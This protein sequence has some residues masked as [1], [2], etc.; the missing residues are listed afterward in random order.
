MRK[1]A[2]ATVLTFALVGAAQLAAAEKPA[3]KKCAKAMAKHAKMY[4][5]WLTKA[6]VSADVMKQMQDLKQAFQATKK[7]LKGKIAEKKAALK[8]AFGEAT[9]DANKVAGLAGEL[10]QLKA[11]MLKEKYSYKA[12]KMGLL[13]AEQRTKLKGMKGKMKHGPKKGGCACGR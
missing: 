7:D 10:G 2:L 1:F 12:K 8:A 6:G 13:T 5:N 11:E 3:C 9:I 4:E